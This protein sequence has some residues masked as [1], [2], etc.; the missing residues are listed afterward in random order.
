VESKDFGPVSRA[1][2]LVGSAAL[3]TVVWTLAGCSASPAS[4]TGDSSAGTASCSAA[5]D[6]ADGSGSV[7]GTVNGDAYASV[8]AARVIGSPDSKS[9]TVVYVFSRPVA[10]SELCSPGWDERIKDQTQSLELK[11]FGK[12][13]ATFSVVKTATPAAGETSVNYTLSSTTSTPQELGASSGQVVLAALDASGAAKGSF[14]LNFGTDAL[15][16]SF[17]AAYCP[18]GHEP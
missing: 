18:G 12:T 5:A 14:D 3:T 16:G 7:D 9:T 11:L 1:W 13:P 10:C 8:A 6:G 2:R 17:D 4:D 15:K